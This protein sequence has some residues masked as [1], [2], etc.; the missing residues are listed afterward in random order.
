MRCRSALNAVTS[1][2]AGARGRGEPSKCFVSSVCGATHCDDRCREGRQPF[3]SSSTSPR[4]RAPARKLFAMPRASLTSAPGADHITKRLHVSAAP[5]SLREH[6][7][8]CRNR[9]QCRM[10]AQ[11]SC[12]I[13]TPSSPQYS[14]AAR[15]SRWPWAPAAAHPTRS[16]RCSFATSRSARRRR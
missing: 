5:R 14:A 13:R 15:C 12:G 8:R 11:T 7:C 9:H 10:S 16:V 4:P 3:Q 6:C 1:V 2:L